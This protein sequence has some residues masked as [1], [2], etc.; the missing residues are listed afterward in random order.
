MDSKSIVSSVVFFFPVV[1][2]F[3]NS[4]MESNASPADAGY[5]N[6]G[7]NLGK[8]LFRTSTPEAPHATNTLIVGHNAGLNGGLTLEF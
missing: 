7:I 1:F 3:A 2:E 8:H 6:P 5:F 4:V